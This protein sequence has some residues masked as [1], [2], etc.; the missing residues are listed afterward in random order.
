VPTVPDETVARWWARR[1]SAFA[2]P[3]TRQDELL[4]DDGIYFA[5]LS[6]DGRAP[7]QGSYFSFGSGMR[8]SASL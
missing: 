8:F 2:H 5:G 3:A 1:K 4:F 6:A 7:P